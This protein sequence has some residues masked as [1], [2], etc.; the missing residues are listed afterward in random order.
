MNTEKSELDAQAN[1]VKGSVSGQLP[2]D[3]NKEGHLIRSAEKYKHP[4]PSS[5]G[6]YRWHEYIKDAMEEYAQN[7]ARQIL[8]I[9]GVS[10]SDLVKSDWN[11]REW[12]KQLRFNKHH[13]IGLGDIRLTIS[14]QE[15]ICDLVERF[16]HC[17]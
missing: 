15:E 11:L 2:I 14:Q 5:F 3:L 9:H 13:H 8:K 1:S 10:G 7:Y 4:L 16:Y 17:R 12:F 6:G